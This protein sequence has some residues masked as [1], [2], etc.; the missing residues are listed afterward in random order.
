MSCECGKP[1]THLLKTV[2]WASEPGCI[3]HEHNP[4]CFDCFKTLT[5]VDKWSDDVISFTVSKKKPEV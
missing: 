1:A 5:H 2:K 4:V 3:L